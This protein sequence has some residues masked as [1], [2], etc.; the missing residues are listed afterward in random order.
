MFVLCLHAL[1]FTTK[2]R[3]ARS[4]SVLMYFVIGGAVDAIIMLK[5]QRSTF[6]VK[7]QIKM[8]SGLT[9]FVIKR[10]KTATFCALF[11]RPARR[12]VYWTLC[13]RDC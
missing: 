6:K 1:S 11:R 12:Y 13:R 10:V 2:S 8:L 9:K 7:D 4:D 3:Y 5:S